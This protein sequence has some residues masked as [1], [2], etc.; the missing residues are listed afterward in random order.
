MKLLGQANNLYIILDDPV[1][2][3]TVRYI[4]SSFNYIYCGLHM[5]IVNPDG[6]GPDG[7]GCGPP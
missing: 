1:N 3:H 6:Q 2:G 4:P 5:T 7:L